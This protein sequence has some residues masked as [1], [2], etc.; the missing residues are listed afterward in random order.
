MSDNPNEALLQAAKNLRS[1]QRAYMADRGNEELGRLV[2]DRARELDAII[3][4]FDVTPNT[5]SVAMLRE[6]LDEYPAPNFTAERAALTAA[7]AALDAQASAPEPDCPH[8]WADGCDCFALATRM[9]K[10]EK[11]D[12]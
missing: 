11:K 1:A 9:G 12:G 2:G 5:D 6:I 10:V 3:E 8:S 7:I 4:L